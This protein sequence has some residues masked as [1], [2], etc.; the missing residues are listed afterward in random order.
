E[1][2]KVFKVYEDYIKAETLTK[3]ITK[4]ADISEDLTKWDINGKDVYFDAN[5][6]EY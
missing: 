4:V 6:L 3:I 2:E 5:N 1:I